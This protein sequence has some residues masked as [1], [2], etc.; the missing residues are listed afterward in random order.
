[1]RL[2]TESDAAWQAFSAYRDMGSGRTHNAAWKVYAGARGLTARN[3][4]SQ[5]KAWAKQNEW[6]KRCLE[7]DRE[8]APA[9]VVVANDI[10]A[11]RADEVVA[12]AIDVATARAEI[13]KEQA[14]VLNKLLDK[15]LVGQTKSASGPQFNAPVQINLDGATPNQLA[16]LIS[17]LKK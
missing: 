1:M 6:D 2:K 17:A 7:Y 13:T 9:D 11:D 15:I 8:N 3:V 16:N 4:S 5:W 14:S 12:F 10:L